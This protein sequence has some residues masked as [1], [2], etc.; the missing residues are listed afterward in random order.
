MTLTSIGLSTLDLAK[1]EAAEVKD[2][3]YEYLTVADVLNAAEKKDVV[4]DFPKIDQ[5]G[6]I[7]L[8]QVKYGPAFAC[9]IDDLLSKEFEAVIGKKFGLDLSQYT[10]MI[11]VRGRC[12]KKA[13]GKIHTDSKDK[14]ITV[15]L[16]LNDDWSDDGGR[17]RV[18]CS[19]NMED[20]AEEVPPTAGSL[21]VFRRC[22][23][24]Y[25]GHLPF[26][27]KRLSLQMNWVKSDRYRRYEK[28]RHG[29]S[30]FLK[31]ITGRTWKGR[32]LYRG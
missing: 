17:L 32:D 23:Y 2:T 26:E 22:D 7:P 16:Y 10:S 3:P 14:V 9:L 4:S 1:L 29:L 12:S 6:S 30:S 27:G 31:K 28:F 25:H 8:S 19:D 11:T 24:S 13:D 5:T 15:L 20:F 21:L 18:L